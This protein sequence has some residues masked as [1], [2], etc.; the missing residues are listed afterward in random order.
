MLWGTGNSIGYL[1]VNATYYEIKTWFFGPEFFS[2]G[3]WA[4]NLYTGKGE[5]RTGK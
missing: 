4:A 3:L 5:E 1:T 2:L